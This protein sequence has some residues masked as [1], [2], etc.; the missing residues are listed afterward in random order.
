LSSLVAI[1]ILVAEHL[2]WLPLIFFCR[3]K[4]TCFSLPVKSLCKPPWTPYFAIS[5]VKLDIQSTVSALARPTARLRGPFGD[6]GSPGRPGRGA[7]RAPR[8]GRESSRR[9][10]RRFRGRAEELLGLYHAA[11]Q[12]AT[13]APWSCRNPVQPWGVLEGFSRFRLREGHGHEDSGRFRCDSHIVL[14]WSNHQ[15]EVDCGPATSSLV[16]EQSKRI[17]SAYPL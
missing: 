17:N 14:E 4:N 9:R 6:R 8:R 15:P 16:Y 7:D 2:H 5:S 13:L 12:H 10:W 1:P 3:Y 11:A